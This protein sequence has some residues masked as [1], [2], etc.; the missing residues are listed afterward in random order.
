MP[1]NPII[2]SYKCQQFNSL[3]TFIS[4][5]HHSLPEQSISMCLQ[6]SCAGYADASQY[7]MYVRTQWGLIRQ[8]FIRSTEN[9]EPYH[10]LLYLIRLA[11]YP[12]R[13]VQTSTKWPSVNPDIRI[14]TPFQRAIDIYICTGRNIYLPT[15]WSKYISSAMLLDILSNNP[16]D[17]GWVLVLCVL[18][19]QLIVR[20]VSLW[21][22][23]L[24]VRGCE[25]WSTSSSYWYIIYTKKF[26][27]WEKKLCSSPAPCLISYPVN[28][29]NV[30][31]LRDGDVCVHMTCN[32]CHYYDVI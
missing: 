19:L 27:H 30:S 7:N 21:M 17:V 20:R 29:D 31:S 23:C 14:L 22:K 25:W 9:R 24:S 6:F 12:S 10:K 13:W 8:A 2:S 11:P 18:T 5:K 15:T 26:R 32:A 28:F 4:F 16:P 1:R 3:N